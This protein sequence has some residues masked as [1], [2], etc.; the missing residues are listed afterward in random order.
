MQKLSFWIISLVLQAAFLSMREWH[1][2]I[3]GD[4]LLQSTKS[5][6]EFQL[7]FL[8]K[9]E[10]SSMNWI[11]V[12]S[13]IHVMHFFSLFYTHMCFLQVPNCPVVKNDLSAF[14][15]TFLHFFIWILTYAMFPLSGL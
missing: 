8:K 9:L 5:C 6:K 14:S 15:V 3:L 11:G 12:A 7:L 2:F 13:V 4:T 1:C 10:I